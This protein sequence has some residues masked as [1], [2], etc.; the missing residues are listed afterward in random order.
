MQTDDPVKMYLSEV[1]TVQPLTKDEEGK[2]WER[3][4]KRDEESESAAKRLIEGSLHLVIPIAERH[5]GSGL[6]MLDLLQEGNSG[7][8]VAVE[9]FAESHSDDFSAYAATCIENAISKAIADSESR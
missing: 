8:M 1:A 9:T 7:L 6:S 5:S 2:L 4:R 3:I